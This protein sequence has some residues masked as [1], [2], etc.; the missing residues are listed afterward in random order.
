M[1]NDQIVVQTHVARDF[2]QSA[3]LFKNEKLVVWEYVSNSLQYVDQGVAPVVQVML[4]STEHRVVVKDNGRGMDRAGLQNFFVMHGENLDRKTGRRG[5][6]RFGTGKAAAFGI[7]DCL[8]VTSVRD[9]KRNVVEL[10]RSDIKKAGEKKIPVR[11]LEV[12]LPTDAPNGTM[13]EV[14]DVKLRALDTQSV[15]RY[16]ERQLARWP[17]K[18]IV[19]I[20]GHTCEYREPPVDRCVTVHP[21]TTEADIIGNVELT[22]K[23][24]KPVLDREQQGVSIFA[25]GVW[26][27]TTLAGV[28][29]QPMSNHI[30]GEVDVPMLEDDHSSLPVYDMSR[31]MQLNRSNESVR[32]LMGFLGREIDVLR[33]SLVK[34]DQSR[35]ADEEKKRLAKEASLI[36][37]MIN[38]DFLDNHG[39][40]A[41]V[42]SSFAL[43]PDQSPQVSPSETDDD[44][45]RLL[46]HGT[47]PARCEPEGG[48]FGSLH[49]SGNGSTKPAHVASLIKDQDGVRQGKPAT[50]SARRKARGGFSVDFLQMG[51][52]EPRARYSRENRTIYVNLDHPQIAAAKGLGSIDDTAFRRLVYEVAF[53][54]YAIALASECAEQEE[55][56]D[57]SDPIFDIRETLNR[58]AR[59]AASLYAQYDR[60]I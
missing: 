43:G 34:E 56:N 18:P 3:A 22:L 45:T 55:Y 38:R 29:G 13:I 20:N 27:E 53:A 44:D 59:Q 51:S 60:Q 46:P 17:N 47:I 1:A 23:V 50:P 54:E 40:L 6:G 57:V 7:A 11:D 35:R 49:G 39:R 4:N 12:D 30:F 16:V 41:R 9:C 25:N 31:S 26:L 52:D 28:E 10:R 8:R 58:M 33:R 19:V 2:E 36:A 14:L 21:Q 32:T 48:D 15:I 5:R 24:A 42:K 37:E